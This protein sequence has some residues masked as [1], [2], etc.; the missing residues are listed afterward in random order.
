ME[1]NFKPRIVDKQRDPEKDERMMEKWKQE[2][3]YS[4]D[5]SSKKPKFS[6]DTPP[7]YASGKWHLGGAV[8]YSQIDMIARCKRMQGYEV[9]FP[10]GIDRNGQAFD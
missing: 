5:L 10:M 2:G 9:L 8:H 3:T 6:M 1:I 4:F 7:P